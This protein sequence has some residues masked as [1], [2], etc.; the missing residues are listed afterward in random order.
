MTAMTLVCTKCAIE[1]PT[2]DFYPDLNRKKGFYP[3]CRECVKKTA[4]RWA[5]ENPEKR[6]I[7]NQR[8]RQKHPDHWRRLSLAKYGLEPE[9]YDAIL[10]SQNGLC[11]I[12]ARECVTGRALHVDHDHAT[13]YVRGLLCHKCNSG[14]G[15]FADSPDVVRAALAYLE[16]NS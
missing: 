5:R 1:K 8:W 10:E 9:D 15:Q 2:I 7:Y 12:C 16:R 13:G 14:L 4:K 6:R 3:S 11:A